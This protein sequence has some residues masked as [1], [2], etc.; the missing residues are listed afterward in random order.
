MPKKIRT[1]A[2]SRA[3]KS[4]KKRHRESYFVF[5]DGKFRDVVYC[6][7]KSLQAQS[8]VIPQAL[9]DYVD[10]VDVVKRN[11]PDSGPGA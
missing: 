6:S 3:G 2:R 7:A 4:W 5:P 9:Q 8:L 1:L 10:H 11:I